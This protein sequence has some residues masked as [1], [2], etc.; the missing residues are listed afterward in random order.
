MIGWCVTRNITWRYNLC[1]VSSRCHLKAAD[2]GRINIFCPMKHPGVPPSRVT[3]TSPV[4]QL[5]P[6]CYQI[7]QRHRPGCRGHHVMLR[8]PRP[9]TPTCSWT[10]QMSV[11]SPVANQRLYH[12]LILATIPFIES[13]GLEPA[14][15][16]LW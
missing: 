4:Y 5:T 9:L 3:D 7:T 16:P 13:R 8:C 12:Y 10:N 15:L 6:G 2:R 11:L 14:L 1:S